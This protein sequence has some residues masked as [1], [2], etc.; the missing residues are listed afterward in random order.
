MKKL[1]LVA[2]AATLAAVAAEAR[3]DTILPAKS[4]WNYTFTNPTGDATWNTTTGVGGI[5][6]SGLAP[7]GNQAGGDP[8]F[9][10]QTYWPESGGGGDDLWV[11][12]AI[13]LTG[14]DLSGI[15]WALGVDNGFKLY[16]NG[17]LVASDNAE[18]YTFR[19]EYSGGIPSA[20][21]TSGINVIA[22]ALEDH[23]GGTA[24]DMEVYSRAVTG[25]AV[26]LPSAALL[27]LPLL[28][29][30]FALRRRRAR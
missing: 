22:V 9:I 19:W 12:K 30:V 21:L 2:V 6:S 24:F 29:T 23:G 10:E 13:D 7:F 3:A 18:G 5:W 14:F 28:G 16:A 26:P 17:N 15:A 27:G 25:P 11:R 4:A 1:L 20:F 8:D